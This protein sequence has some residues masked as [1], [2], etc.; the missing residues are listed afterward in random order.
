MQLRLVEF[1]ENSPSVIYYGLEIG[2]YIS[3]ADTT[4]S[5]NNSLQYVIVYTLREETLR[6]QLQAID[7]MLFHIP[8]LRLLSSQPTTSQLQISYQTSSL[9]P[10]VVL[11]RSTLSPQVPTSTHLPEFI[12]VETKTGRTATLIAVSNNIGIYLTSVS[13]ILV[14]ATQLITH[15][16][17]LVTFNQRLSLLTVTL[18]QYRRDCRCWSRLSESSKHRSNRCNHPRRSTSGS[19]LLEVQSSSIS[20]VIVELP[21]TGLSKNPTSYTPSTATMVFPS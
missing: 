2:G 15:Y 21:P 16:A 6:S 5:L 14:G 7:E 11:P 13:R 20:D 3:T 18:Y 1:S 8:C 17:Q 9:R 19:I 10:K 4:A 12:S